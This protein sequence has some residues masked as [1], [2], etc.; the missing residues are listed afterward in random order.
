M[1]MCLALNGYHEARGEPTAGELAVNHVVMNRVADHRY[2]NNVCD[3]VKA[4]RYRN[5]QPIKH[6]CHFSWWCDGKSDN[7]R[8][9]DAWLYSN[10]LASLIISGM[11]PDI[12]D[13]AT[14]YHKI[15]YYPNWINDLGMVRVGLIGD[16]IFYRWE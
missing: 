2:K 9:L 4:G 12:T 5:N 10:Q 6:A 1:L 7:P 15:G 16:H 8:D 11:H 3:V 13:G 14:H